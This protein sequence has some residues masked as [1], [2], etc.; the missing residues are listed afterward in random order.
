MKTPILILCVAILLA[1]PGCVKEDPSGDLNQQLID[2]LDHASGGKGLSHYVLPFSDRYDLIPQDPNNSLNTY[3]VKLGQLLYHETALGLAPLHSEHMETYSCASC[4]F[5]S[6]GFQAGRH[7][8]IADG[9]LGFFNRHKDSGYS[10]GELD[11]QPIRSPSVLNTAYQRVMLWNGQFGAVGPNEGT[12][13]A[14][15]AG[16]PKETNHLGFEG[17]ETQA[18]AGLGVH[19]MVIDESFITGTSYGP[20]FDAAF[21]EVPASAR[22]TKEKAGLAIAAYERT[23]LANKAPFQDWL[24]GN[25]GAMTEEQKRGAVLFFG[26]A[27]CWTCHNGPSLANMEFH[28]IGMEDLFLC[29]EPTFKSNP[30]NAENRG[31]GGFT[32]NPDDDYKFKVPQLYNLAD[33]PFYGHGSSFRTIRDVVEYK[34]AAVPQSTYIQPSQLSPH[35]RPLG[36]SSQ[37][38]SD[39]TAFIEHALYDPGLMRYQPAFIVSGNCFPNNDPESRV[40]LGCD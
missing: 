27:E 16:T 35:F 19:R 10:E 38:L 31:R 33:S 8:G 29:P 6:A 23:V 7:Q 12:E 30:G 2:A 21:P 26:K 39:I 28:A 5:A 37:E 11:V 22:Y 36:L 18:I 32:G 14:W 34:N 25:Y 24:R 9:G 40:D 4:H 3:K 1:G 15:T 17:L 20:L 13:T